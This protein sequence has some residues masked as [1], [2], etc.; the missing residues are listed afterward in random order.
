[1]ISIKNQSGFSLLEVLVA[2][3]ILVLVLPAAYKLYRQT[4]H[5]TELQHEYF[6]ASTIA[7]SKIKELNPHDLTDD[8]EDQGIEHDYYHWKRTISTVKNSADE[9]ETITKLN[10]LL[11]Q[12]AVEVWWGANGKRHDVDFQTITLVSDRHL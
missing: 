7:H 8:I 11:K 4:I 2:F 10:L 3:A 12:I 6:I 9:V 5:S 1:M